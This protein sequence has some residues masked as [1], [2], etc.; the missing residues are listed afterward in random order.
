VNGGRKGRRPWAENG[1]KRRTRR[2]EDEEEDDDDDE[3]EEEEEEDE[4][5]PTPV[6]RAVYDMVGGRSFA[7]IAGSNPAGDLDVYLL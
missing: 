5:E 7:G 1:S 3:E 2:E 4:R 6:A